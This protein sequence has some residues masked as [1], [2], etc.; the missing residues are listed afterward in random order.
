[1]APL[2]TDDA[3]PAYDRLSG[4]RSPRSN[5]RHSGDGG[6]ARP[7]RRTHKGVEMDDLMDPNHR[8]AAHGWR[9]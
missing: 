5:H 7:E 2:Q 3:S 6:L 1:L 9:D 8:E 4:I